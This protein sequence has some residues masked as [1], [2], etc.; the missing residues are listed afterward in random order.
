V[1]VAG[2]KVIATGFHA[3]AGT[4]HAEVVA[5][6]RAGEKARGATLYLN[7]EPCSHFGRTP[8]C[9]D[10]IIRAGIAEVV[11]GMQDP[12][13]LVAGRGFRRLRRA[14]VRVRSG[15]LKKECRALNA[16]FI[17]YIT[18]QR[19][20]VTLKLAASL[21]GKIAAASGDAEWIS[22][23]P[24]RQLVH[25]M[26]NETD[27]VLVGADTVILDDPQLTCRIAAGR[28]P[29]RVILD[30]RLRIPLSAR[31]LRHADPEKTIIATGNDV[32]RAKVHALT[33]RGAQVWQFALR[34]GSIPWRSLLTKLARSGMTSVLI[35]GG[36]SV[37]AS[38][39]RA[40]AVDRIVFFYAPKI[41]GGD[42]RNMVDA[43][44][45]RRVSAAIRVQGLGVQHSGA[46]LVV[47]GNISH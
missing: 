7:L 4:D 37:A 30:G 45:I 17:T 10:A 11:A 21:D 20:L 43:L 19:P 23:A 2:G 39:L 16:A 44:S 32:S 24:S 25:R 41:I 18:R 27:A 8:P 3:A 5:L 9:A 47:T 6:K 12:N 13:P 46:D 28:N 42:G 14:G 1:I 35:E 38:A 22:D 33:K 34:G 15:L 36:A 31:L 26:R 29:R 40:R